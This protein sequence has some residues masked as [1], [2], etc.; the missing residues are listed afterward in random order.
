MSSIQQVLCAVDFSEPSIEALRYAVSVARRTGATVHAVHAWQLPVVPLADGGV[1][2]GIDMTDRIR[3]DLDRA[4]RELVAKHRAPEAPIEA[5]LVMGDPAATVIGEAKRLGCDTIVIG[6]HG[7]SGLPRAILGSVAERVV[8]TAPTRV[9][10]VPPRLEGHES[11]ADRPVR[12][13][14]CAVDFSRTSE[15]ALREAVELAETSDARV[16]VVHC[17]ELAAFAHPNSEL[18]VSH[19][20]QLRQ[21]LEGLVHRYAARKAPLVPVIRRGIHY[22]EIVEL[23]REVSADLVVIGTEGKTGLAHLFLGSVAERVV[24][25]SP[26][27]VL[28]VRPPR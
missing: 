17:W 22:V 13:I 2:L 4:I 23:A 27:P 5:H 8:R 20:R 18:A 6:T 19:E 10:V 24:R 21:D 3:A 7:R 11:F 14:L 28:T 1:V 16:H 12:T 9:F 26:V 15:E 25:S